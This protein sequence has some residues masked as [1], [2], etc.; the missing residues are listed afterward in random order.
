MGENYHGVV[1]GDEERPVPGKRTNLK[2][3]L[4]KGGVVIGA[5]LSGGGEMHEG[6]KRH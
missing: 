1:Q 3:L 6:R 4:L 5:L 2:Y